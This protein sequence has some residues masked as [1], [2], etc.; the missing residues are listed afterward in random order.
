MQLFEPLQA[1]IFMIFHFKESETDTSRILSDSEEVYSCTMTLTMYEYD[2][3][4]T[5]ET[6]GNRVDYWGKREQLQNTFPFNL[7]ECF[8]TNQSWSLNLPGTISW[9]TTGVWAGAGLEPLSAL[10]LET[11]ALDM[12]NLLVDTFLRY[13]YNIELH[14]WHFVMFSTF[15]FFS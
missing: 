15:H 2:T 14:N 4:C 5:L 10:D 1:E 6:S 3:I 7:P 12:F 9:A 13:C 8:C 11:V